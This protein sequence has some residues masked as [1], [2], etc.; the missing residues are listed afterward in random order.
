MNILLNNHHRL[1]LTGVNRDDQGNI[2]SGWVVNGEWWLKIKNG[3]CYACI[4]EDDEDGDEVRKWKFEQ[5]V[6]L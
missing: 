5:L 6:E 3:Q 2:I 1:T 4:S